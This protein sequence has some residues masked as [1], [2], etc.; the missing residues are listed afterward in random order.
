MKRHHIEELQTLPLELIATA[1]SPRLLL[2]SL[3]Q[4]PQG[5]LVFFGGGILEDKQLI[6]FR[7]NIYKIW[8]IITIPKKVR[9]QP[10]WN[11][12]CSATTPSMQ[13]KL[14]HHWDYHKT[15]HQIS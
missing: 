8:T 9:M 11:A 1:H 10:A 5:N 6:R 4:T 13:Q 14:S 12:C 2:H 7:Q 3:L 15:L